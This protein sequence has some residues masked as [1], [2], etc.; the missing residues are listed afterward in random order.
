VLTSLLIYLSVI[1]IIVFVFVPKGRVYRK[2][3]AEASAQGVVTPE[4][5]AAL[6]DPAV[7]AARA[8]EMFMI[9][10]LVL[11]MVLKPF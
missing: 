1:P 10:S 7:R 4:L 6:D 9:G 5:R 3:L 11:L 8:Y 2:A